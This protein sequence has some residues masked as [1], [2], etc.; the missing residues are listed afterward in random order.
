MAILNDE[1]RTVLE[2]QLQ[3][4]SEHGADPTGERTLVILEVV[5]MLAEDDRDRERSM[6][7]DDSRMGELEGDLQL[8]EQRIHELEG[9]EY[10]LK[11][12]ELFGGIAFFLLL[13]LYA[14]LFAFLI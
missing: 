1:T 7:F 2:K 5:K 3:L 13:M 12:I 9:L 6:R 4:L 8:V 14:P 11:K 10:R